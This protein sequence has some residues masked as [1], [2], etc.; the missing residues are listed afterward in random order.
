MS[1][2]LSIL[3]GLI[4]SFI[5]GL[6]HSPYNDFVKDTDYNF[7]YQYEKV[8]IN[9]ASL[10]KFTFSQFL[11]FYNLN[12]NAWEIMNEQDFYPIP[13]RLEIVVKKYN[14]LPNTTYYFYHPIFFTN[15]TEFWKYCKWAKKQFKNIRNKAA[16]EATKKVIEL[17]QMD[18]DKIR[19]ENEKT[20]EQTEEILTQSLNNL[21]KEYTERT[22][23]NDQTVDCN[24]Y[25]G[26][27]SDGTIAKVIA[28]NPR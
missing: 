3:C 8:Q 15:A 16:N 11:K 19:E 1:W 7:Q 17:V 22:V 27:E 18:I 10:P 12:P 6:Y 13:A 2:L 28:Y 5:Y 9:G 23:I 20:L 21:R 24:H 25:C 4:A 26:V 14:Y